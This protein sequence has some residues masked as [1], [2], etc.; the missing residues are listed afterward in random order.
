M[1]EIKTIVTHSECF[2]CDEVSGVA[3]LSFLY[4]NWEIIRT[5]DQETLTKYKNDKNVIVLDVGGEYNPNMNN[6]DHHQQSFN[7]T[8][9]TSNIKLSSCGLI[10]KH[11][12][13]DIFKLFTQDNTELD[14]ID[15]GE[16]FYKKYILPIDAIDNGVEQYI[17]DMS[18]MV[19]YNPTSLGEIVSSFNHYD[20]YGEFQDG[21]FDE[22][23]GIV[24]NIFYNLINHFIQNRINY[25]IDKIKLSKLLH[26]SVEILILDENYK[27]LY[28][29]LNELDPNQCV[30]LIV[31]PR[32][33]NWQ[34]STVKVKN[35]QFDTLV[36]LISQD[37]GRELVGDDL[38]FIHN[39]R[40][41]GATKTKET[42]IKIAHASLIK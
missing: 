3:L 41:T 30:K 31:H 33:P 38:V 12:H 27:C 42:A 24:Q 1:S 19:R 35:S 21:Q 13:K 14:D 40:F 25:Q 10:Y 9:D 34:I 18:G 36:K 15:L 39:V 32:G 8:W 37:E 11:F 7:T 22:A 29:L 20:V 23:V 28:Q 6:Y 16:S 4:P 26:H 5:R 17:S 2:H